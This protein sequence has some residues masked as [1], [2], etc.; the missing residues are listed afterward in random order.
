ML[1]KERGGKGVIERERKIE[2]DGRKEG[3]RGHH[4][5]IAALDLKEVSGFMCL[6]R[7]CSYRPS[8]A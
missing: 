8:L 4:F 1:S 2:R 5:V 6:V 7:L 3:G